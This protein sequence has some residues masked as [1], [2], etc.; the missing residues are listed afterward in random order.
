MAGPLQEGRSFSH[1]ACLKKLRA[2]LGRAWRVLDTVRRADLVLG[3][4]RQQDKR[5]SC[6]P[7]EGALS[8]AA[9]IKVRQGS[10]TNLQRG[11]ALTSPPAKVAL[12][13]L[14]ISRA[15]RGHD[16]EDEPPAAWDGPRPEGKVCGL[17]AAAGD[18]EFSQG[19]AGGTTAA[20]EVS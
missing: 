4:V 5:R 13:F 16:H 18:G 17:E 11:S 9:W 14:D 6:L 20:H 1:G 2:Q 3:W 7:L 15:A 12:S 10:R 8:S 19:P